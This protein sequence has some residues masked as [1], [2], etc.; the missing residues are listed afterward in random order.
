[1]KKTM[2]LNRKEKYAGKAL[3]VFKQDGLRLSLD[4]ISEKIGVT[5]KTLYNHFDSKE[6]LLSE[7]IHTFVLDL[8]QRMSVMTAVDVNAI[9]GLK[10]GVNEIAGFFRTL[11][12]VF[13]SDIKKMYPE[14]ANTEH[15]TGFAFFLDGVK[16]NLLKG[17]DEQLFREDLNVEL[18]S[19]YFTFSLVSFFIS[20]VANSSAFQAED[21]FSSIL[22]YHL[23]AIVT[24]KG[25][26][27]L[28]TKHYR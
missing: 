14:I 9:D 21:Y 13:L 19:Q 23:R 7:C 16:Q 18:I 5:K 1:M 11:S 22:E 4:E 25:M 26:E 10:G 20:R 15:T 24:G 3:D 2:D 6:E 28:N 8:K 17:I 12:P 27:L